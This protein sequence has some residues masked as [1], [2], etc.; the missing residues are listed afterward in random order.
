MQ[1]RGFRD[2]ELDQISSHVEV[3]EAFLSI[4]IPTFNERENIIELIREIINILP[5][6]VRVEI[7]IIDDNSPD[8]TGYL[9]DET[10]QKYSENESSHISVRVVHRHKQNGLISAILD[11]VNASVGK[12][13]LIMDADFSHPP[14]VIPTM[15]NELNR[16]PNSIV[17]GSRYTKGGTM[18]GFSFARLSISFGAT[19]I[20]RYGLCMRDVRDPM[21]GFF[22]LSHHILT[23][24]EFDTK[25]FKILLEILIKRRA[26]VTVTEIPYTFT[27]RSH[28][29]SKLALKTIFDYLKAVWILYNYR[30]KIGEEMK[31]MN[32]R[33]PNTGY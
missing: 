24:V 5:T 28:G 20:A 21:S 17:I 31:G 29:K 8:G 27:T 9:V 2:P 33:N 10:I 18:K 11:G 14:H 12:Y 13:V 26:D 25:G 4:V 1:P 19:S 30:K 7:L 23:E 22:A 6:D 16:R 15:I 32:K 3:S